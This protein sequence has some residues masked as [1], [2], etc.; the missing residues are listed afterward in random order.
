M[1]SAGSGQGADRSRDRDDRGPLSARRIFWPEAGWLLALSVATHFWRLFTPRAVVFDEFHYEQFAGDY[2]SGTFYFDV[3][4]PLGNLIYAGFA[5]LLGVPASA[6]LHPDPVPLLRLVPATFGTLT[7]VLVYVLLMQLG[8]SRRVAL[9]GGLATLCDNALLVESRL[10]LLDSFLIFFGLLALALYLTARSR[11]G[12]ARCRWL[13]ACAL[14]AGCALTVKWTGAS[15]LGLILAAWAVE[16]L[17]KRVAFRRLVAEG[18]LLVMIPVM[19]Y[20]GS[21][22]V[23][24]RLLDHAGSSDSLMS[25]AFQQKLIGN[26]RYDPAAPTLSFWG[27]LADVH[28]AIRA[29]NEALEHVTHVGASPW[30]TWPIMKHPMGWWSP[31][32]VPAGEKA[33]IVLVGNPVVWWGGLAAVVI[34]LAMFLTRR[35][36]F[37]GREGAY[38]LALGGVLLNFLPFAGI[39]RIMYL[40][41]YLFALLFVIMLGAFST[42]VLSGWMEAP[43]RLWWFRTRRSAIGYVALAGLL[44]VGFVYF[45]PFTYGG[46]MS[47]AAWDARFWVLHPHL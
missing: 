41:H 26:P 37:A 3:H 44:A 28:R 15:A 12:G 16:G 43:D 29:G 13:A 40:Y 9:L 22:A 36:R 47:T 45:L 32:S 4:P 7:V 34:G 11:T 35:Q 39:Q 30:Y 31:S 18:A 46:V 24:F 27:K 2:L 6:L 20:V 23:H 10:I 17:V 8:S 38:L 33:M 42:G 21:F 25:P 1:G 5:R 19:I 14:F